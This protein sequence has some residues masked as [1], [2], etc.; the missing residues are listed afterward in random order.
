MTFPFR[1]LALPA[2]FALAT[3]F[4]GCGAPTELAGLVTQVDGIRSVTVH[5]GRTDIVVTIRCYNE[6]VRPIGIRS[7]SV[8]LKLN[9]IDVG[10]SSSGKPLGTQA[11]SSNTQDVTFAVSNQALADQLIAGIR[12][13]ALNY[14]L[15][16]RVSVMAGEEEMTNKSTSSGSVEVSGVKISVD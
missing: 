12:R 9:G 10:A 2:F 11:L 14:E 15:Q 4:S 7:M 5:D 6:T 1:R 16:T 13:G 3:L 8:K